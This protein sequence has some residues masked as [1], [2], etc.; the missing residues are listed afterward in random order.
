MEKKKKTG[1]Y[2]FLAAFSIVVIIGVN[3]YANATGQAF[4]MKEF[5]GLIG[6]VLTFCGALLVVVLNNNTNKN[7][8]KLSEKVEKHTEAIDKIQVHITD[9]DLKDAEKEEYYMN[10]MKLISED[11]TAKKEINSLGKSIKLETKRIINKHSILCDDLKR[12]LIQMSDSISSYIT[13]EFEYGLDNLD[14]DDFKM[15]IKSKVD[16]INH[17]IGRSKLNPEILNDI[18][19]SIDLNV[20][21]YTNSLNNIQDL[22]NGKRRRKFIDRTMNFTNNLTYHAIEIFINKKTA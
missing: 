15:I 3:A 12:Y 4:E 20:M 19:T 9:K 7:I 16:N 14:V 2:L 11:M 17:Q 18:K 5:V 10:A 22:E 13:D 8:D 6:A 21:D 1:W